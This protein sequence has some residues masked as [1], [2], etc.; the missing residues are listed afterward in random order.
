MPASFFRGDYHAQTFG[1]QVMSGYNF[2]KVKAGELDIGTITPEAGLRYTNVAQKSYTNS[3]GL[4]FNNKTNETWT[5]VAGAKYAKTIQTDINNVNVAVTPEAKVALTYDFLRDKQNRSVTLANG[6][7]YATN[8]ENMNRLGF[9]LGAGV[10]FKV[11]DAVDVGVSYEGKF[12]T[13]YSDHTG[14]LNVKYP[15]DLSFSMEYPAFAKRRGIFNVENH[16]FIKQAF[17]TLFP[18]ENISCEDRFLYKRSSAT[19]F[20]LNRQTNSE[21]SS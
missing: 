5:A 21:S 18:N 17:S 10:S 12:K 4:H 20:I 6:A 8:G 19:G 13:D 3:L 1:A 16:L 2:N 7:T 9:E 14:L 15:S 11:A